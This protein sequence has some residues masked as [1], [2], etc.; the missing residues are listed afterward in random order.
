[1]T[2][3]DIIEKLGPDAATYLSPWSPFCSE[4]R[5]KEYGREELQQAWHFYLQGWRAAITDSAA[6][7]IAGRFR[8]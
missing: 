8:Y 6:S 4:M 2:E 3:N 1:M 5:D 7:K